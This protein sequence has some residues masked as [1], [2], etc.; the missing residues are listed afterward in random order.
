MPDRSRTK[1]R[2]RPLVW[3]FV[4]GLGVF[5]AVKTGWAGY[6]WAHLRAS[7]YPRAD[8]LL[9]WLPPDTQGVAIVDPHQIHPAALGSE[10]SAVRSWL[11]RVR[12]DVKKAAGV[13]LAFDVDK[14]ALTPT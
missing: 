11:E 7:A 8:A 5:L 2:G 6:G 3:L 14:I 13:D 1:S 12:A 10:K 4:L 9:A